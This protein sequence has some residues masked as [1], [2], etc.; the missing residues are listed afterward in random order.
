MNKINK[1]FKYPQD[2]DK[3]IK[4]VATLREESTEQIDNLFQDMLE[5]SGTHEVDLWDWY[6]IGLEFHFYSSRLEQSIKA[7]LKSVEIAENLKGDDRKELVLIYSDLGMVYEQM[8][9]YSEALKVRELVLKEAQQLYSESDEKVIWYK[10]KLSELK[11]R[12]KAYSS[13]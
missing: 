10:R 1:T 12:I 5:F 9:N 7:F 6:K 2:F 13:L 8:G 4:S 3:K 11:D